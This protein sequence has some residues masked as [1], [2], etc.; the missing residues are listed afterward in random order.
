MKF[1]LPKYITSFGYQDEIFY[2]DKNGFVSLPDEAE[3]EARRHGLVSENERPEVTKAADINIVM[4]A[5]AN[6][7]LREAVAERDNRIVEL[8]DHV[9]RLMEKVAELTAI[10]KGLT[11]ENPRAQTTRQ[12]RAMA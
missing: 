7:Q 12:R 8:E 9:K 6:N 10:N 11:E 1:R 3:R 5:E 4:L 2:P